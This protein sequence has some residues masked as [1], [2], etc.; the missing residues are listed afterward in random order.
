[1]TFS[2]SV[3]TAD[4]EESAKIEKVINASYPGSD[5]KIKWQHNEASKAHDFTVS[6]IKRASSSQNLSLRWN[7]DA[8]GMN[9]KDKLEIAIPAAG[10]FKVLDVRAIQ[11]AEE[12]ALVQF[13]DPVAFNQDLK[14]L[15]AISEQ[16][17]ISYTIS[18]SEV[19]VY[20]ANKLD[21]N[22][23]VSI[24][25]GITNEWGSRLQ[26]SFTSNVFFENRLPSVRIH[27]RGTILPNS[28]G[29]LV[30]PFEAINLNAVDV[31][32]IKIYENNVA[33]FLQG[34][35]MNG[36]NELRQVA[37]PL[38][39]ATVRLDGDQSLN[40]HKKNRFSLDIDKYIRTEPGAIYRINIA[41]RPD[42]SLY[43]CIEKPK[44]KRTT[45]GEYVVLTDGAGEDKEEE[46]EEYRDYYNEDRNSVDEDDEFW[47]RYDSYYPYGYNWNQRDNPA[48]NLTLIKNGLQAEISWQQTLALPQK[49]EVKI[50]W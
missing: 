40:L 16:E 27:G 50:H 49:K 14:G 45:N 37:K 13:S 7:G 44:R 39:K 20:V 38:V 29:R 32:V 19:K 10:D 35:D 18:G 30:L 33:Q 22:F 48:A 9:Q 24:N 46:E 6:G 23:K 15:I 42:Y 25:E 26:K 28:S 3:L 43:T 47:S 11:D 12:Y 17:D 36:E 31:S 4:V 41:F 2:G 21:G 1:M 34:N 5:V 8:L